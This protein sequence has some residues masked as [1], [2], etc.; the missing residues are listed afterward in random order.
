MNAKQERNAGTILRGLGRIGL[1][2][3][4]GDREDEWVRDM[5]TAHVSYESFA[6]ELLAETTSTQSAYEYAIWRGKANEHI[7]AIKT[8]PFGASATPNATIKQKLMG[9]I[10]LCGG[11]AGSTDGYQSN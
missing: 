7:E 1:T 9:Y 3:R 4:L 10:H 8:S 6:E 11:R 5:F 2:D